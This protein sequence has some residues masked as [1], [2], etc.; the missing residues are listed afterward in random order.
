MF[1]YTQT[2]RSHKSKN[3]KGHDDDSGGVN[4]TPLN[5]S[6]SQSAKTLS[7]LARQSRESPSSRN[8]DELQ[9]PTLQRTPMKLFIQPERETDDEYGNEAD[10]DFR[11]SSQ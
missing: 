8:P 7:A 3:S 10:D 5:P 2:S 6:T 9:E 1:S 4:L 11:P